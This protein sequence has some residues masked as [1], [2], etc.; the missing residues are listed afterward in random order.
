MKIYRINSCQDYIKVA[1]A[2]LKKVFS[3]SLYPRV[4]L[5]VKNSKIEQIFAKKCD[6]LCIFEQNS[7]KFAKKTHQQ[8]FDIGLFF[9]QKNGDTYLKI[10][11]GNGLVAGSFVTNIFDN[12]FALSKKELIEEIKKINTEYKSINAKNLLVQ[13]VF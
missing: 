2:T 3:K 11:D 10:Y 5:N 12:F 6:F 7:Q 1:Y 8:Y 4:L 9:F 13:K